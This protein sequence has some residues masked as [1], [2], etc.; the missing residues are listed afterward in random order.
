MGKILQ[1][2]SI[3]ASRTI[4]GLNW[5]TISPLYLAIASDLAINYG[6]LGIVAMAF[7]AGA[8]IFQIPAGIFAAKFGNKHVAI[9]GMLILS[10]ASL[11]SG[12]S[13]N[14]S[15][16][17]AAR[18][19]LGIGAAFF[20]SPSLHTLRLIFE[21]RR[22][23]IVVGA[24]NSAF[25]IGAGIALLSWG[26]ISMHIGWRSS[27]ILGGILGLILTVENYFVLDD[28]RN[29]NRASFG[30]VLKN[31]NLITIGIA[32]AGFWGMNYTLTQFIDSYLVA[33]KAIPE[34]L[35]GY[36]SSMTLLGA[37]AGNM[38]IGELTDRKG[39]RKETLI[40]LIII[41]AL[42]T[43]ATPFLNYYTLWPYVIAQGF[44]SGG[45]FALI[46]AITMD[47]IE[48]DEGLKPLSA[49]IINSLNIGIG[50][51][52]SPLYTYTTSLIAP[53]AGWYAISILSLALLTLIIK[54]NLK[55]SRLPV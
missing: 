31:R 3:I 7:L 15:S 41:T 35:A 8:T 48:L 5:Y 2:S 23:G 24:Y 14:F 16:L 43:L 26:I 30:E 12:L 6:E 22:Q 38:L 39:R 52:A 44:L 11:F 49:S 25:N 20:F 13:W 50:S 51:F 21:K 29:E 9:L 19:M 45:V 32:T 28:I 4:Y 42:I 36:T 17:I 34:V 10:C 54:T 1:A 47:E 37:I 33:Y 27:L 46:Y 53:D 55:H 40:I 18:F